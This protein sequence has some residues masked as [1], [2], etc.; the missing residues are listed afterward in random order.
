MGAMGVGFSK[1]TELL[2]GSKN[3]DMRDFRNEE[4]GQTA[5]DRMAE[6]SGTV[7]IN[8]KT[9]KQSLEQLMGTSFYQ[10]LPSAVDADKVGEK[11]PRIKEIQRYLRSFRSL[12]RSEMLREYPQLQQAY[13]DAQQQKENLVN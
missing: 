6:L 12:A 4:G 7:K 2:G 3:L 13:Y 8:N 11:S 5:Y 1:P 10:S 9:L